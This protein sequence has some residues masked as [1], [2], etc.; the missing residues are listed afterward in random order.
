[1]SIARAL[2]YPA[3]IGISRRRGL[4]RVRHIA[5]GDLWIQE[6]LREGQLELV[7]VLG[8]DNPADI[9][10]KAIERPTLM[11]MMDKMS[12]EHE[13]GRATSAPSI[14]HISLRVHCLISLKTTLKA[15]ARRASP[16]GPVAPG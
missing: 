5:V 8:S 15:A 13:D 7:K 4:G 1:M 6:K 14:S 2:V 12:L 16:C 3:A 11:K 10:T 9:F